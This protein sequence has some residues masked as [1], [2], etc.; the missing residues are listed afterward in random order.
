[1]R[2]ATLPIGYADGFLRAYS[3]AQ[4]TV[5]T[6]GGE[7]QAPIV[8]RICMDQCMIDISGINAKV[9]DR[10]RI[11]GKTQESLETLARLAGTINYESLCILSA[12][13]PR[14]LV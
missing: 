13:V 11:F 5:I 9:G 10:V 7:V 14:I 3:G 12:R 8:G 1:M 4:I 6:E 2:I